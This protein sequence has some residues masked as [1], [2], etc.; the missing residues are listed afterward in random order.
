MSYKSS[1]QLFSELID[2]DKNKKPE[3]MSPYV[4]N[5]IQSFISS[6]VLN[7]FHDT[8]G[9]E[10]EIPELIDTRKYDEDMIYNTILDNAIKNA[11]PDAIQLLNAPVLV[12]EFVSH[13]HLT[14]DELKGDSYNAPFMQLKTYW[15]DQYLKEH[16]KNSAQKLDQSLKAHKVENYVSH[17]HLSLLDAIEEI[18]RHMRYA[19]LPHNPENEWST[20]DS[21][22][23]TERLR[24]NMMSRVGTLLQRYVLLKK[25]LGENVDYSF[26]DIV[27]PELLSSERNHTP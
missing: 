12:P 11:V 13:S 19:A 9:I 1:Q 24:E 22:E 27:S 7:M 15:I 16:E 25:S 14:L 23:K 6:D 20:P 8:K 26:K 18:S 5:F 2:T 21:A 3:H 17:Y 4:Y 10:K